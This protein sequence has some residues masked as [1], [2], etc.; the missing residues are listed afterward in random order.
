MSCGRISG[1]PVTPPC[2]VHARTPASILTFIYGWINI[3]TEGWFAFE[4]VLDFSEQINIVFNI[5]QNNY[6][7]FLN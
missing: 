3:N 1:I 7:L 6:I 2:I 4:F 5:L